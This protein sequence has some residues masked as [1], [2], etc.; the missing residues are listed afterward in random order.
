MR[1]IIGRRWCRSTPS[2]EDA[3]PLE[4]LL[5]AIQE[6]LLQQRVNALLSDW[7]KS[8]QDQ[9]QV[10]ILDPALKAASPQPNRN[11]PRRVRVLQMRSFRIPKGG[12]ADDR[13]RIRSKHFRASA[14]LL[15]RLKSSIRRKSRWMRHTGIS[16]GML[17]FLAVVLVDRFVLL[18][19]FRSV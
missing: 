9:G 3:P 15:L 5:R 17:V 1:S 16:F 14:S 8:L 2:A 6:I 4:K 18:G 13:V 11:L 12:P 10:E 19:E 7:L